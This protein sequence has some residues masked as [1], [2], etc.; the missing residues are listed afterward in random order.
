MII[1]ETKMIVTQSFAQAIERMAFLDVLPCLET[2]LV[3]ADFLRAEIQFHGP[4][5]GA[6]QI[7]AGMDFA[8]ELVSNM[9]LIDHPTEEQCLDALKELVNVTCGLVLPLVATPDMDQ[10]DVTIPHDVSDN[11]LINWSRWIQQEDV[12]VLDVGGYPVAVRLIL[13]S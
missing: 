4:M 11:E 12:A 1:A 6:V 8:R 5:D 7:V 3:P 9:G 2:P 10:F 13:E